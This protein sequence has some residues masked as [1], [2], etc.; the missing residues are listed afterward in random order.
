MT[1]IPPERQ[2]ILGLVKGRLS[3][4]DT[5]L[6]EVQYPPTSL[7][8]SPNPTTGEKRVTITLIGTPLDQTFKDPG[9]NAAEVCAELVCVRIVVLTHWFHIRRMSLAVRAQMTSITTTRRKCRIS[10]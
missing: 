10:E 9:A 4:D 1:D 2:K 6:G 8:A 7:R 5:L 3:T